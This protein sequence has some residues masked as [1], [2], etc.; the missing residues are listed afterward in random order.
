MAS[1]AIEVQQ[2][3]KHYLGFGGRRSFHALRGIDLHVERGQV[4]GLLGPNGAGKTTLIK[5]LLGIVRNSSG[6]A[7][8]LGLPAGSR[9]A[10]RMIGYLPENMMFP[11]HH[12]AWSAM[13]FYG[14]LSG[15]SG[16][17]IRERGAELLQMVGLDGWEN[18]LVKQFSKGM[19]QRLCLAQALLHDPQLLIMDEPTDGLDPVGRAEMRQLI[20][21]LKNQGKT[22]FLNSHIL[23]EVELV[24]DR[25]AILA[26]GSV[27][28]VG[29][30]TELTDR[31]C[32]A[33]DQRNRLELEGSVQQIQT[34]I[35]LCGQRLSEVVC[36]WLPSNRCQLTFWGRQ[37]SD[38]DELIDRLRQQS[39]SI[40]GLERK[41]Q[42]LEEIFL[43]AIRS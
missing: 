13:R 28:G 27:R 30:L 33:P 5:I 25:V 20:H 37:Q 29:T 26:A 12:T 34:A 19:R 32:T 1:P 41:Q 43:T 8:L 23:Q 38:V 18:K 42:S 6:S 36:H 39:V 3:H 17:V 7:C 10:R 15:V 21:S 31:F 35:D 40:R 11:R 2:L 16:K 14:R 9:E 4:F 24:C 22:V